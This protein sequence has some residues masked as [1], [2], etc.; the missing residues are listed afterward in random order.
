LLGH[1]RL[2]QFVRGGVWIPRHNAT[3]RSAESRQHLLEPVPHGSRKADYIKPKFH[4]LRHVTTRHARLVVRVAPF[5][6][7]ST[8]RIKTLQHIMGWWAARQPG[9]C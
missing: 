5:G 4:L 7:G 6:R 9:T 3:E 2:V 8:Y 1:G